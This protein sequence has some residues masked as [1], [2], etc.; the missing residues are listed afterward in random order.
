[1]GTMSQ[2]ELRIDSNEGFNGTSCDSIH[3]TNTGYPTRYDCVFEKVSKYRVPKNKNLLQTYFEI[4][5]NN[6]LLISEDLLQ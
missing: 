6:M 5:S 3:Y 2:K 4:N 1:M